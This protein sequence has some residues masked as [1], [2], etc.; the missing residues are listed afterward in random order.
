MQGQLDQGLGRAERQVHADQQPQRLQQDV[1]GESEMR[2]AALILLFP[3]LSPVLALAQRTPAK[4]E[5]NLP[6]V[7][8]PWEHELHTK[9]VDNKPFPA[10]KI[11]GNLYYVGTA[12]YA[13]FLVTSPE[14]H[15][16]INPD[17]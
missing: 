6:P 9:D 2:R 5:A 8:V 3:A 4:P 12:D 15:I 13:S 1:R 11:A 10:H 7:V 17:F 16:L 14:G